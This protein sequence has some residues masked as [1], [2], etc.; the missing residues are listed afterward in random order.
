MN[1]LNILLLC[2]MCLRR[3]R[4]TGW[5]VTVCSWSRVLWHCLPGGAP[6]TPAWMKVPSLRPAVAARLRTTRTPNV[7]LTL[8]LSS[9]SITLTRFLCLSYITPYISSEKKKLSEYIVSMDK[10]HRSYPSEREN[11]EMTRHGQFVFLSSFS[12]LFSCFS[13][14]LP[15]LELS[16]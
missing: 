9:S 14:F 1:Y 13:R 11:T 5:C 2:L 16:I 6:P 4:R 15:R 7:A 10:S 8:P 12:L 3:W